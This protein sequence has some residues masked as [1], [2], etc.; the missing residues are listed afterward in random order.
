MVNKPGRCVRDQISVHNVVHPYRFTRDT[1]ADMRV[2][3]QIDDKFIVGIVPQE[4]KMLG[5]FVLPVWLPIR[6]MPSSQWIREKSEKGKCWHTINYECCLNTLTSF[7][8]MWCKSLSCILFDHHIFS[9]TT[10]LNKYSL[11][12]TCCMQTFF[13]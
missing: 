7:L 5:N 8:W 2:L 13:Y 9:L 11:L 6:I 10:D 4:G 1:L 12:V 3:R